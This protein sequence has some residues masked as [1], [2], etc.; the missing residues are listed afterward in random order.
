MHLISKAD[1]LIP[2]L[3]LF[4]RLKLSIISKELKRYL[5]G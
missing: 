4:L 5:N 2:I 1:I 3:F